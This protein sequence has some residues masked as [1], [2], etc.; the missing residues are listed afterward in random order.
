MKSALPSNAWRIT[1][2]LWS[3]DWH[4]KE[5][6][7]QLHTTPNWCHHEYWINPKID[8][9]SWHKTKLSNLY[10]E[11]GDP[12]DPNNWQGICFKETSAKI[13]SIIITKMT[14][15]TTK[16]VGNTLQFGYISC[17]EA[18]HSI[19]WSLLLR[20]QHRLPSYVLFIDCVKVFGTIQHN[21][22]SKFYPNTVFPKN[23][24]MLWKKKTKI[25]R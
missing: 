17:Q 22:F 6:P 18:L 3:D 9:E 14:S 12:Q 10:K 25:A 16:K 21:F 13:F 24:S 15:Q 19:R 20:R 1:K 11:K 8:Y 2:L 23:S 7:N 5:L 4:V